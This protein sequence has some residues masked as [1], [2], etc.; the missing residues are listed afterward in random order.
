M[1]GLIDANELFHGH[2]GVFL[3]RGQ[4]LVAE[5]FLDGAQ[6]RARTKHMGRKG[7]SESVRMN[8]QFLRKPADMMVDN[9]PDA[10]AG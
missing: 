2:M 6:V 8:F 4:T 5:Q 10:A 1:T 7:V 3:R 9:M